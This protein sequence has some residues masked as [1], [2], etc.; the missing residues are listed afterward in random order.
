[1]KAKKFE[2]K[3]AKTSTVTKAKSFYS[4]K[5]NRNLESTLTLPEVNIIRP[6]L[7]LSTGS[8]NSSACKSKQPGLCKP[9]KM[10]KKTTTF[11]NSQK[12]LAKA[13][14]TPLLTVKIVS[15]KAICLAN[16]CCTHTWNV[17][18]G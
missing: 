18:A 10:K 5:K 11:P 13:R 1:M 3:K 2:L 16:L 15:Q 9:L 12:E 6:A 17:V 4:R 14:K 7:S 8:T